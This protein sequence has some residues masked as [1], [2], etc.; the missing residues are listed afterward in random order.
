VA[1]TVG[2][3][4]GPYEVLSPLGAGGMGEVY[5][6]RDTKLDRTVALKVLPADVASDVRALTRF[7]AEAKAI[8][9][10]SHPNILAIHDFGCI[11]GVSFV[12]M[13]LLEG[14]TLRESLSEGALSV[15]KAVEYG[16]QIAEGLAAAHTKGIV[17]RDIKPENLFVTKEGRIKILDFGLARHIPTSDADSKARTLVKVTEPGVVVGTVGY[18]SPEQVRGA[19][20]DPRSDIFAF[21]CVLYEMLTG[22]RAFVGQTAAVTMSAILHEDPPALGGPA[23]V[24]AVVNRCLEK[25]PEAR[26]QSAQDLAFALRSLPSASDA[27]AAPASARRSRVASLRAL[28]VA[29]ALVLLGAALLWLRDRAPGTPP[30]ARLSAKRVLVLPFE[31][32]THDQRFD[33]VGAMAADWIIQGLTQTGVMQAIPL[34]TALAYARDPSWKPAAGV[35]PESLGSLAKELGAG[36]VVSGAF[37]LSGGRL[38]MQAEVFDMREKKL[39][40]AVEPAEASTEQP[41]EAVHALRQRVMGM[42][43]MHLDPRSAPVASVVNLPPSFEAYQAYIAGQERLLVRDFHGAIAFFEQAAVASPTF[44]Q[45]LLLAAI[46][47]INLGEHAEAEA[48]V[49]RLVQER[50]HLGPLE[51]TMLEELEA[52]QRGDIMGQLLASRK[53]A[54]LAPMSGATFEHGR[55][56]LRAGRPREAIE[57]LRRLP[58]DSPI[59][60]DWVPYWWVLSLSQHLLGDYREELESLRQARQLHPNSLW[61][62]SAQGRASIALGKTDD[63]ERLREDSLAL[64]GESDSPAGLVMLEWA[65]ELRWHGDAE[66]SRTFVRHALEWL[67]VRSGKESE[68]VAHR[69][70]LASALF[71]D[72]RYDD[73]QAALARLASEK[74]EKIDYQVA[75]GMVAAKKGDRARA[76]SIS[77]RLEELD[78]PYLFGAHTRGRAAIAAWLGEKDRAVAL[79]R[80]ALSQ[81]QVWAGMHAD[82]L[83]LPLWNELPFRELLKPKG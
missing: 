36:T 76:E 50:K 4:L 13:E 25:R 18:L 71:L 75:L 70:I 30:A 2:T 60:R 35:S 82:Y 66:R 26:F 56:A 6:A 1:L 67:R 22:R 34:A 72:E 57:A 61:V 5:R 48:I 43:A 21:G 81:G 69:S 40:G 15:R 65:S 58:S 44:F 7:E 29:G 31:N 20:T 24:S 42:L 8:A 79:M 54:E 17:H 41:L 83:L 74:P 62:V 14:E 38:Q 11:E 63:L 23:S 46:C 49:K 55:N 45:P 80:E 68:S 9:A 33:A 16:V 47:R 64:H 53:A 73:A 51:K 3:R 32:R 39:L 10:L 28:G 59:V 27:A 19:P 52:S 12:V 77:R 37:Y 78:R